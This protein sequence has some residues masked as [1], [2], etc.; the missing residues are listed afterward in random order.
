MIS[1]RKPT[2]STGVGLDLVL[3]QGKATGL[4]VAPLQVI[5]IQQSPGRLRHEGIE[6]QGVQPACLGFVVAQLEIK[7]LAPGDAGPRQKGRIGGIHQGKMIENLRGQRCLNV[8]RASSAASTR[9]DESAGLVR[10]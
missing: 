9:A 1:T 8:S 6:A 5:K 7:R 10:R 3:G 2:R 4:A